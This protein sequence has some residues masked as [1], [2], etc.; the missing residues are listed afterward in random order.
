LDWNGATKI[1][2]ENILQSFMIFEG[3]KKRKI[4]KLANKEDIWTESLNFLKKQRIIKNS[5]N[6]ICLWRD[7]GVTYTNYY[8]AERV[9]VDRS[10][11][12]ML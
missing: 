7:K 12:V 2:L 9:Y 4:K 8:W 11:F 3:L 1:I 6:N 10:V 5:T